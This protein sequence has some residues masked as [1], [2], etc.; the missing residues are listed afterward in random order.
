MLKSY[1]HMSVLCW[2]FITVNDQNW[3]K[4]HKKGNKMQTEWQQLQY[5]CSIKELSVMILTEYNISYE[6]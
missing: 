2:T 1:T 3:N 5:E 4:K 6:T